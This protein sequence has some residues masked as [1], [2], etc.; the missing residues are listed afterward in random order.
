M[1]GLT[2]AFSMC[3]AASFLF[4]LLYAFLWSKDR[5]NAARVLGM[6][7][8]LSAAVLAMLELRLIL[9]DS[10]GRYVE[11][12]RWTEVAT[13]LLIILMSW[14]IYHLFGTARRW[15]AVTISAVLGI[16]M[17][18]QLALPLV[19]YSGGLSL[20]P[21]LTY[22]GETFYR[23]LGTASIW[24]YLVDVANVLFAIYVF[25]AASRAWRA[26]NKR[27]ASII[28]SAMILF[29][30]SV[31]IIEP[32]ADV[33]IFRFPYLISFAF[34]VVITAMTYEL[35]AELVK[36]SRYSH[37]IAT[38]ELR[39]RSLLNNLSL[40]IVELD[41]AGDIRYVNNFGL[42]YLDYSNH[43]L[44]GK[45]WLDTLVPPQNRE[46]YR[47]LSDTRL[48][49]RR[50]LGNIETRAKSKRL[51][52]WSFVTLRNDLGQAA[53]LLGIAED[54][55]ESAADEHRIIKLKDELT[56][57]SRVLMM[58]ELS[59]SIAHELNQPLTAIL[60]N[61]EAAQRFLEHK[62]PDLN[63][64]NEILRDIAQYGVRCGDIIQNMRRLMTRVPVQR[65]AT[66]L[67][68]LI[69]DVMKMAQSD[70][71][72]RNIRVILDHDHSSPMV[73]AD[74]VQLQQVILNLLI[75]AFHAIT[76]N[77][78]ILR[79]VR[80]S[81][82][83][84]AAGVV[85]VAVND[86]GPGIPA[87]AQDRIFDSFYTTK[88]QGMGMGLPLCRTIVEAHGGSIEA[89]NVAGGAVFR[90]T[91]PLERRHVRRNKEKSIA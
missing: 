36:V 85:L 37:E 49:I 21:I 66:D 46:E 44:N 27:R 89:R 17:A 53:G 65:E 86:S 38:G 45:S 58:G 91:I 8:S 57:E 50:F 78:S 6:L 1:S 19:I 26:G 48:E 51:M 54:I 84:D 7:M 14:F 61:A 77:E 72:T 15:L 34:L 24:R 47:Q 75:N 59:A 9:T 42:A 18:M 60:S 20:R 28:G 63:E 25:D 87:D 67:V 4:S 69:R 56:F 62:P 13:S 64:I 52:R 16:Y 5:W 32:L 71:I 41:L 12:L 29:A 2:I 81:V 31:L 88:K 35:A 73:I 33:G 43:A 40:L 30:L 74:Q 76:A 22:W 83:Q 68:P 82:E 39:W 79:E 3:A 11:L 10:P 90:F 23:P 70:A 55:T 80:I